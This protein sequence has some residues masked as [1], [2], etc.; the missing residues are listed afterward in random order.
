MSAAAEPAAE[1]QQ[2]VEQQEVKPV[3][4]Q[5]AVPTPTE[6]L[7]KVSRDTQLPLF[8][9]KTWEDHV[10]GWIQ[11]GDLVDEHQWELGAIAASVDRTFK[12][13]G[14]K[15]FAAEV[16]AKESTVYQ[17]AQVYQFY[18][19]LSEKSGE[20]ARVGTLSFTHHAIAMR[21]K[22]NAP[23]LLATAADEQLS[24]R[25]LANRIGVTGEET[26]KEPS[27]F[28]FKFRGPKKGEARAKY[29]SEEAK[30]HDEAFTDFLGTQ[31]KV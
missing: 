23:K 19:K 11:I 3:K 21:G 5:R 7:M 6:G 8:Q 18:S 1:E 12:S 15:K 14:M 9:G 31:G 30:A 24:T 20:P 2:S 28:F 26:E 16:G 17:Y 22:K 13:S 25:A 10:S 4:K 29:K 27:S